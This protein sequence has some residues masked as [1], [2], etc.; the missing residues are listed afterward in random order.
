MTAGKLPTMRKEVFAPAGVCLYVVTYALPLPIDMALPLLALCGLLAAVSGAQFAGAG[1][2]RVWAPILLFLLANLLSAATSLDARR[3]LALSA[4]L[5]PA[6]AI[7]LL[8]AGCFVRRVWVDWLLAAH[9]VVVLEFFAMLCVAELQGDLSVRHGYENWIR[10]LGSPALVVTNDLSY[11]ALLTPLAVAYA[12]RGA[13]G[14]RKALAAA[15]I[16]IALLIAG[17]ARSRLLAG[18]LVMMLLLMAL[19]LRPRLAAAVAAALVVALG[20]LDALQGWPLAGRLAL[21]WQPGGGDPWGARLPI[22]QHAW[23]TFLQQPSLGQG[24][25]TFSFTSVDGIHVSWAHNLYLETLA[26]QG[27]AG[28]AALLTLLGALGWQA[29]IAYRAAQGRERALPAALL[30]VLAGIIAGGLVEFTF[31]RL[32][33]NILLFTVAGLLAMRTMNELR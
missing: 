6:V 23:R 7:Y 27:I 14:W 29:I 10:V 1:P 8:I 12:M 4:P 28:F 21:L 16:C 32:W 15:V 20:I 18:L 5:V 9:L 33:L 22:W 11:L 25:H 17:E 3:S 30:C 31:L 2:R 26:E 24:P 13:S 19:L